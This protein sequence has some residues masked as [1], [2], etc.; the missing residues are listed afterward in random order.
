MDTPG[1][2]KCPECA[3]STTKVIHGR[4]AVTKLPPVTAALLAINIGM[5][6]LSYYLIPSLFV[7]F[8]QSNRLIHA[9][10]WWRLVTGAFLHGGIMHIFFN[11]Y[12]LWLFGPQIER[13]VGSVSFAAL[14][15]AS[16]LWGSALF[17]IMV[18]TGV[19][20]GASGAIFGLFGGWI[21]ASYRVRHTPAG[22]RLFRQ[23]IVLLGINM[24]LPFIIPG[25]A[26]QAHVGGLI[27]GLGIVWVWQK[28]GMRRQAAGARSAVAV[29]AA[30]VA[31][32]LSVVALLLG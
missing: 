11:M 22:R 23:L 2:Q 18:P 28:V 3:R 9:G 25:V 13:Q 6:V 16:L 24:F 10:E 31:I 29:V 19:A 32:L 1:G 21:A 4:A 30:A 7:L 17:L 14:Y 8:E 5:F 12:A 26:W 15:G 20:I 27:A